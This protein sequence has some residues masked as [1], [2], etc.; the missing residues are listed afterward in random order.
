MAGVRLH[1]DSFAETPGYASL[2]GAAQS[3]GYGLSTLGLRSETSLIAFAPLTLSGKVGWRHVYGGSTPTATMAFASLP[4]VPFSV[5]GAPIARNAL[6]V[7]A[8]VNWRLTTTAR[9]GVYYS[10]LLASNAS[11]NAIKLKL[12]ASF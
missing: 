2:V 7:E 12:D 8:G 9:L 4:S 5:A 1:T 6:E 10:G 3:H 11:G